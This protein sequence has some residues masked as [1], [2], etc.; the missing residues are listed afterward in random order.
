MQ[1]RSGRSG[2][3]EETEGKNSAEGESDEMKVSDRRHELTDR[4]VR[5][6][7]REDKVKIRRE[8]NI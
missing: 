8:S 4:L 6:G 7:G 5:E 3:G 1:G 2:G